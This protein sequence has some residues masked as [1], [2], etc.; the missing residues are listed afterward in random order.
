[1]A[2]IN[3]EE[4]ARLEGMAYALKVAKEDGI[5]GLEIDIKRRNAH[6]IPLSIDKKKLDEII[7]LLSSNCRETITLLLTYVLHNDFGYGK[8]RLEDV[9]DAFQKQVNFLDEGYINWQDI[10]DVMADEC[11]MIFEVNP[12]LITLTKEHCKLKSDERKLKRLNNMEA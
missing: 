6:Y 1:M 5:E 7:Y 4:Q 3:K 12:E 8:K 9:M 10:I 2:K 11:K